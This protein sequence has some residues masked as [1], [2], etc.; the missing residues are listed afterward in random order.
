[1]IVKKKFADLAIG[2]RFVHGPLP[3]KSLLVEVVEN[4][5]EIGDGVVSAVRCLVV[6]NPD[7]INV[8]TYVTLHDYSYAEVTLVEVAGQRDVVRITIDVEVL[9]GIDAEVMQAIENLA[10]TMYAQAEDGIYTDGGGRHGDGD[11]LR[12]IGHG[13]K[14]VS[15]KR[16][17]RA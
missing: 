14:V 7:D 13:T 10:G 4:A 1:M 11:W 17:G 9:G 8:G 15:V 16:E 5:R 6:S 12:D 3:G 2:E